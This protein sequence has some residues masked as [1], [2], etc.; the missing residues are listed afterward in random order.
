[1]KRFREAHIDWDACA[2]ISL[3]A[4]TAVLCSWVMFCDA[5]VS[6]LQTK[7]KC[8]QSAWR[9]IVR[10]AGWRA[11]SDRALSQ[12]P[13][14]RS[15]HANS[16]CTTHIHIRKTDE[17]EQIALQKPLGEKRK[18]QKIAFRLQRE[19]KS[20]ATCGG[21]EMTKRRARRF[22]AGAVRERERLCLC[23]P[24]MSRNRLE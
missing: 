16:L 18:T 10:V 4:D 21:R 14:H 15:L 22:S 9:H 6:L 7:V 19:D 23:I 12:C 11:A 3:A 13:A 1:M 8:A 5:R 24:G 17:R 2:L 20:M